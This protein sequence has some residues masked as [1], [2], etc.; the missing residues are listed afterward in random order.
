MTDAR[1]AW[2]DAGEQLSGLGHT[3]KRQY[4]QQREDSDRAEVR[5]AVKRLAEA[6]Q[7]AF[8]T[9]GSAAKDPE[10][11]ADVKQVGQSLGDAF[12]ATL[13]EVSDDL[14]RAFGRSGQ[15]TGDAAEAGEK[16]GA[17]TTTGALTDGAASGETAGGKTTAEEVSTGE[18]SG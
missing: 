8:E 5:E 12:G 16:A 18:T 17:E 9:M 13:A 15:E 11:R 1:S 2:Q 4:Q 14:R 3:L 10:V 6:V 7:D